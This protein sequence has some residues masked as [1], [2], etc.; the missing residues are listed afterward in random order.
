MN[1]KRSIIAVNATAIAEV[2]GGM[3]NILHQFLDNATKNNVY[4]IFTSIKVIEDSKFIKNIVVDTKGWIKRLLWEHKGFKSWFKK[5]NLTPNYIISFQ[6]TG[7]KFKNIPQYIYL[8][9][10]IPFVENK[11]NFFKKEER[12]LWFYKNVFPFF[13]KFSTNKRT[14]FIVQTQWMKGIVHKKLNISSNN[15]LVLRPDEKLITSAAKNLNLDN[16][17][18]NLF[19]PA[20]GYKYKNHELLINILLDLK[21]SNEGVFK[22]IKIYLTLDCT[23]NESLFCRKMS[24]H[25]LQN[26][27]V[28]LGYISKKEVYNYYRSC[29]GLIFPSLIESFGLPLSEAKQFNLPIISIN[30]PYVYEAI[31]KYDKIT[32]VDESNI[33]EWAEA[34]IQLYNNKPSFSNNT[35]TIKGYISWKDFQ[36]SL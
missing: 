31:G 1:N 36:R 20:T 22:R 2:S 24:E 35:R 23:S 7:V 17:N 9:N 21:K 30:L 29:D 8:Q 27:F 34:I 15:L 3:L 5:E 26:S 13:I 25:N 6:N 33:S 4:Y 19:Y 10:A 32:L 12:I 14:K 28:L 16:N 11:W 18:A